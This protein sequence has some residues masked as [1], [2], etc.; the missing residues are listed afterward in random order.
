[1][2]QPH[3]AANSWSGD[4]SAAPQPSY[5]AVRAV[6]EASTAMQ[7]DNSAVRLAGDASP[8]MQTPA[9]D[10][11]LE[12]IRAELK[13]LKLD[14]S[15]LIDRVKTLEKK[16]RRFSRRPR[17]DDE[18]EN[19]TYS[20]EQKSG[21]YHRGRKQGAY[22]GQR[23]GGYNN[24]Q[25]HNTRPNACFWCGEDGH[26]V[27]DCP[28]KIAGQPRVPFGTNYD[29]DTEGDLNSRYQNQ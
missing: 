29:R 15:K 2:R 27:A 9:K 26:W 8:A 13:Q 10:D 1:M 5:A 23:R 3:T 20:D 24:S 17:D 19:Q 4:D 16:S 25:R 7:P 12:D 21:N 14:K 28:K 11:V 22:R 6:G 18:E